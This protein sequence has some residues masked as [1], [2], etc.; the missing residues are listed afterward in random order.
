MRSRKEGKE[1]ESEDI[2]KD[3]KPAK[4]TYQFIMQM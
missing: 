4:I 3:N 2:F 1:R